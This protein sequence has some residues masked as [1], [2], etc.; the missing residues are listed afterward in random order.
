MDIFDEIYFESRD[1]KQPLSLPTPAIS[2]A[3]TANIRTASS[4]KFVQ[5]TGVRAAAGSPA[6]SLAASAPSFATSSAVTPHRFAELHTLSQNLY[7]DIGL[8]SQARILQF[9]IIIAPVLDSFAA[10][11][12][13]NAVG[14]C[15]WYPATSTFTLACSGSSN[16]LCS[17]QELVYPELV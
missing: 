12:R 1:S 8:V 5:P 16:I 9:S 17:C 4:R 14:H 13:G 11:F 2:S 15:L 6:K 7:L 10:H 3:H